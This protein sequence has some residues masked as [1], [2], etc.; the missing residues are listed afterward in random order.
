MGWDPAGKAWT[1]SLTNTIFGVGMYPVTVFIDAEGRL[2]SGAIG[3]GD[4]VLAMTYSMLARNGIRLTE[5]HFE[6]LVKAG[7][8]LGA[9]GIA[10]P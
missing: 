1:D 3:M 7:G 9:G 4:K 5:E 6:A 8:A 2:W 10:R